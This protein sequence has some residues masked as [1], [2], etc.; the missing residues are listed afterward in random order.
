MLVNYSQLPNKTH[1]RKIENGNAYIRLRDNI[2]EKTLQYE[3]V[4]DTIYE[5]DEVEIVLSNRANLAEYADEQ[6]DAL[7]AMG[8]QIEN[9]PKMPTEENRISTLEQ[10]MLELL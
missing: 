3:E 10:A 6:F 5:C 4:T 9:T 8:K 2:T 7:F 1:I